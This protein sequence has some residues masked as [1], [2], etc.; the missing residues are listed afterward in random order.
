MRTGFSRGRRACAS[1]C[2]GP[3]GGRGPTKQRRTQGRRKANPKRQRRHHRLHGGKQGLQRQLLAAR[4]RRK[5]LRHGARKREWTQ[6][7]MRKLRRD[8]ETPPIYES[9]RTPRQHQPARGRHAAHLFG[10]L[11]IINVVHD[12]HQ[13][14]DPARGTQR[15]RVLSVATHKVAQAKCGGFGDTGAAGGVRD[16]TQQERVRFVPARAPSAGQR[17]FHSRAQ[18]GACSRHERSRGRTWGP[19]CGLTRTRCRRGRPALW[20]GHAGWPPRLGPRGSGA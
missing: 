13:P 20:A 7:A 8:R 18:R 17:S 19:D 1:A 14:L 15:S 6:E 10:R 4:Q 3:G 16:S 12:I 2:N 11:I 9:L 5:R